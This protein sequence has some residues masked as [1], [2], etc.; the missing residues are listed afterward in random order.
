[1]GPVSLASGAAIAP[2]D[3]TDVGSFRTGPLTW[4]GGGRINL[5]LGATSARSDLL[6][7]TGALTKGAAGFADGYE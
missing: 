2:S 5:R 6:Q 1:M 3:P 7:V 4:N